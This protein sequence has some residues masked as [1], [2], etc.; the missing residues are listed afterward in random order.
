MPPTPLS[1]TSEGRKGKAF[2]IPRLEA[3]L[4]PTPAALC[5]LPF[6]RDVQPFQN[7]AFLKHE[8]DRAQRG[9]DS[10][11]GQPVRWQSWFKAH[12]G[13]LETDKPLRKGL[14]KKG[15]K[16]N[17]VVLVCMGKGLL[18]RVPRSLNEEKTVFSTKGVGKWDM[19]M[20]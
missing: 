15:Y 17:L 6:N 9:R 12:F 16:T 20:Q 3:I 1:H 14:S 13:E 19:H 11:L 8:M 2:W 10:C 5:T 4:T 18:P 7:T